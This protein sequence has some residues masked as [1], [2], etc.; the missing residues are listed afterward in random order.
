MAAAAGVFAGYWFC[1]KRLIEASELLRQ[2]VVRERATAA[3]V[4][5]FLLEAGQKDVLIE[6]STL[7]LETGA[8]KM[9]EL[10]AMLAALRAE[11]DEMGRKL[12]FQQAQYEKLLGQKKSS[13]VR[14]G[15]ITEQ[16]SP[17]LADYPEDPATARFLGEPLDFVHFSEHAVVFV[18]VKSGKSQLNPNQRR[19]RDLINAGKVE[20]KI[21]RVEGDDNGPNPSSV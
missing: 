8:Q 1:R 12:E 18:E 9:R 10:A 17:F 16:M 3:K 7:L 2:A 15:K 19:I 14:T 21:Y 4:E 6:R 11:K 13:E 20:F 5:G